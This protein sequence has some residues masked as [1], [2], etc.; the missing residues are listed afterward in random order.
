MHAHAHRVLGMWIGM[1]VGT[2][3]GQG[4]VAGTEPE[5][6]V[7]RIPKIK[8]SEAILAARDGHNY[9]GHVY[10]GQNYIGHNYT[11]RHY[12]GHY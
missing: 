9:I 5:R 8:I 2:R 6:N 12:M 11:G 7:K 4:V 1:G 3:I 10:I